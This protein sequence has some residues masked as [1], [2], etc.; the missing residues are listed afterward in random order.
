MSLKFPP[1]IE[2][3]PALV[4]GASSGIGRATA[5]SLAE[6]GHPVVVGARRAEK[7]TE[8]V[9]QITS[10]GGEATACPV[11]VTDSD[12]V[13]EFVTR[14][15]EAYGAPEVLVSSAG[16]L[17]MGRVWEMDPDAFAAQI[18]IHLL[19]VQRLLHAV[20]PGMQAR[21]AGSIVNI[22]SVNA[23][24]YFGNPA[25]SAAKAGVVNLTQAV[26]SEYGRHGIRCNAVLPGSVRTDAPTWRIRQERDPEIFAR[27]A[28][29]YPLGRVGVA[30]GGNDGAVI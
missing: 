19:S 30:V 11:D 15:T 23:A 10:A 16:S 12:S 7:L 2:R 25:Y 13:T 5:V 28:R 22:A 26:A 6:A 20:L 21:R 29:W 4:T 27:L 9:E 8:L 24:R 17:T 3:R 1:H 18:D 14:A